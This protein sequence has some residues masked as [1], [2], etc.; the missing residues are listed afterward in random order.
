MDR[1][2]LEQRLTE[3]INRGEISEQ[4]ARYEMRVNDSMNAFYG[5]DEEAQ[6]G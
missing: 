5:D 2:K 6:N 3:A 1:D 4:E